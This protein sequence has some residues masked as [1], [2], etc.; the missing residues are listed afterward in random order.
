MTGSGRKDLIVDNPDGTLTAWPNTGSG[1][2]TPRTIG[3]GWTDPARVKFADLTGDGKADLISVDANGDLRAFR[4]IDGID[5]DWADATVF[6]GGFPDPARILFADL[7][8]DGKAEAVKINQNGTLTAWPNHG[9]LDD[10]GWGTPREIGSGWNDPAR[11]RLADL[12][13]DGRAELVSSETN[14]DLRAFRN[15]DGVNANWAGA[16]TI[17]NGWTDPARVKFA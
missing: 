10:G 16:V 14:G 15:I 13:G 7:N 17:G 4:N 11:I 8:G 9:V 12:N 6:G 5:F 3:T 1:Y 2:G